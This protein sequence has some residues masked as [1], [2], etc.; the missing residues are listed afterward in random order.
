MKMFIS[1]IHKSDVFSNNPGTVIN[2]DVFFLMGILNTK[3]V[4]SKQ[5]ELPLETIS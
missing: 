1:G 3:N 5:L 4:I 2:D